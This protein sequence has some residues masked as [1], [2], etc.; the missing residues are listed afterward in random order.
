MSFVASVVLQEGQIEGL[1]LI[2]EGLLPGIRGYSLPGSRSEGPNLLVP[3]DH[4]PGA[5]SVVQLCDLQN[6]PL[7]ELAIEE[8]RAAESG[9]SW[10]AGAVRKLRPAEHGPAREERFA[11]GDDL[12]RSVVAIFSG[13]VSPADVLRSM[14]EADGGGLVLVAHGGKDPREA[15]AVVGDLKEVA[16]YIPGAK[17]RFIPAVSGFGEIGD[18]PRNVVVALGAERILDFRR[19]TRHGRQGAVLL[20]TGL[21]GSGKSTIAQALVDRLARVSQRKAVLLDGDHVRRELA[22]ELG[23]SPKDRTTNL[24]R[25]AWVAARVAEVGGI[26]VCA[27]IAPFESTRRRMRERV[28]PQS[29]FVLIHVSTPL[30]VAEARDRKGLYARARAGL[31]PD[32]TGIDSPYEVPADADIDIDTATLTVEESVDRIIDVLVERAV[33]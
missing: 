1:E 26:A 4:P 9:G 23:F 7:A 10:L 13:G 30:A 6:T 27:P 20:F 28:E 18:V 19:P 15:A 8:T 31:I 3:H 16:R 21:S 14:R 24:L 32:F 22:S 17:A 33:I 29:A 2:T 11:I 12:S 5:G 25:Q